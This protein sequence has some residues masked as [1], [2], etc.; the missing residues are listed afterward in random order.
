MQDDADHHVV[1]DEPDLNDPPTRVLGT[2]RPSL[3]GSELRGLANGDVLG[4]FEIRS[5]LG[6]GG[7]GE[8]YRA[9]D[10]RLKRD[11]AIKVLPRHLMTDGPSRARF[12]REV[13][14]LAQISHDNILSVF[15]YGSEGD[16]TYAVIELLEGQTLADAMA[17]GLPLPWKRAVEIASEIAEGLAAAHSKGIT[18]RDL[19]P[20]N[21]FLTNDGRVKI[22]DFGLAHLDEDVRN[23]T[24]TRTA[25]GHV[26]GSAGYMAP[27]QALGKK[28][29][30]RADIFAFGC[31]LYEMLSGEKAFVRTSLPAALIAIVSE[32]PPSLRH[33]NIPTGLVDLTEGCLVKEPK[34]RIQAATELSAALKEMLID[35]TM[36]SRVMT[37]V[38]WQRPRR[39]RG[40]IAAGVLVLAAALTFAFLK[41]Q[42]QVQFGGEPDRSIAVL[43]LVDTSGE[44]YF[45]DGL[46]EDIIARLSKIQD[47][48]VISRTSVMRFKGSS[49]SLEDIAEELGVATVL[50][51]KIRR[52]G[53]KLRIVSEL[54]DAKTNEILWSETYNR[55]TGGIFE[56]QTDVARQIASALQANLQ[57]IEQERIAA[58][59]T[60]DPEAFRLYLHGL[61]ASN[62]RS[63]EGFHKAIDYFD[64]ALERDPDY[65]RAY[66]G[67]AD[68]YNM[69]AIYG[70][71]PAAEAYEKARNAAQ[72]A[73]E[74][75]DSIPESHTSI[76][77]IRHY[78]D[79]DLAGSGESFRRAL[80]ID[81]GHATAHH[82]YALLLRNL[83]RTSEALREIEI[84]R[85]LDPLS[86]VISKNHG[87]ILAAAG[88]FQEAEAAL[89][90]AL[91]LSP[92]LPNARHVLGEV[93]LREQRYEDALRIFREELELSGSHG[94]VN[95]ASVAI[96]E[97]LVGNPDAAR[98][99]LEE[100]LQE[101]A[102]SRFWIANV[103]AALGEE[104]KV[105]EALEQSFV[106]HDQW[107][108]EIK[109]Q[110]LMDP[111][112]KD[113]RYLDLLARLNL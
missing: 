43:P 30:P 55:T 7:M 103:Y 112:R 6:R 72:L 14:A 23:S 41:L 60:D 73:I 15:D 1:T 100:L 109:N 38:Q 27:E 44:D 32:E 87:T 34:G 3:A 21:I 84:A 102:A 86:A 104:A 61:F 79:W 9:Y 92:Q 110:P 82:W 74:L 111:Y 65:A 97:A 107:L 57:P 25:T 26:M 33:E 19:K 20:A 29:D 11:V 63:A 94:G 46:T 68:A 106:D 81:P 108:L 98:D 53:D 52:E 88:L 28:I 16:I 66:S 35:A 91:R 49:L 51:G 31:I 89:R 42:P 4:G 80:E 78:Y 45:G 101:P 54:V 2:E 39:W 58:Q 71:E 83:G 77:F 85:E 105:F 59:P 10:S 76:A 62:Q 95:T 8:V 5:R 90:E 48:K 56:I 67:L 96:G 113:S 37:S 36:A 75:D 99:V 64:A 69:L 12:E 17:S 13:T 93:Y 70:V 50:S 18:H 40:W 24:I 47:L 22:L